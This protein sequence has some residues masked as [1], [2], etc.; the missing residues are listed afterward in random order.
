MPSST[1][2]LG[3]YG[4]VAALCAVL[5]SA[6][7]AQI[8]FGQELLA[9]LNASGVGSS[10]RSFLVVGDSLYFVADRD[11]SRAGVYK[12]TAGDGPRLLGLFDREPSLGRAG[13]RVVVHGNDRLFVSDG[14]GLQGFWTHSDIVLG[15]S[16]GME[17]V[18]T[19]GN[20]W[21]PERLYVTDGT[22]EGTKLLLETT[23][24][25][26]A[27]GPGRGLRNGRLHFIAERGSG[28][29]WLW[30]TDGKSAGTIRLAAL[31]EA[32]NSVGVVRE[33][34]LFEVFDG[35]LKS[36]SL[37]GHGVSTLW[38]SGF[39]GGGLVMSKDSTL[40][41]QTWD[42]D[43]AVTD[44]SPAGTRLIDDLPPG[45]EPWLTPAWF[46]ELPSAAFSD[47]R[48]P[49]KDG[50]LFSARAPGTGLEPWFTTGAA[51]STRS[52]GDL[53]PGPDGS[54][55]RFLLEMGERMYFSAYS[56]S[57][58]WELWVSDGTAPGTRLS[59]D[60][61]PGVGSSAP[62]SAAMVGGRFLLVASTPS[63]G[64]ELYSLTPGA[65][66][67]NL[68]GDLYSLGT[69]DSSPN[70]FVSADGL[71]AFVADDGRTGTKLWTSDGTEAGTF[72]VPG[73]PPG[74]TTR[75]V[76]AEGELFW[77]AQGSVWK[78][79]PRTR[80]RAL[81]SPQMARAVRDIR[82]RA[83]LIAASLDTEVVIM[84]A[85]SLETLATLTGAFPAISG[86]GTVYALAGGGTVHSWRR[87]TGYARATPAP[88]LAQDVRWA[89][90]ADSSYYLWTHSFTEGAYVWH[91]DGKGTR[92]LTPQRV[93]SQRITVESFD[94]RL[95]VGTIAGAMIASGNGLS[96][97]ARVPF[98][99]GFLVDGERAFFTT[100]NVQAGGLILW[101]TDGTPEG[102]I[103][104]I[105]LPDLDRV[106]LIGL[107]GED[108]L[109]VARGE[110]GQFYLASP[111]GVRPIGEPGPIVLPGGFVPLNGPRPQIDAAIVDRS[112]V[113]AARESRRGL[114]PWILHL[115][116]P[117]N[118]QAAVDPFSGLAPEVFPNPATHHV[119]LKASPGA[120][121][122][123][124]D[125]LG[126]QVGQWDV[127]GGEIGLDVSGWPSGVYFLRTASE[128]GVAVAN[129]VVVRR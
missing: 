29:R 35:S 78:H 6:H 40:F 99:D 52:L 41:F 123:A 50:M 56:P 11:G 73:A 108:M 115:P 8:C 44:G 85:Q 37:S 112:V 74:T 98:E 113:F 101:E 95:L 64:N 114:E 82:V 63:T 117:T 102:T 75:P 26:V 62:T 109:L 94:D 84:D 58:G 105:D 1:I 51:G 88:G 91:S 54:D 93:S 22:P 32:D 60:L 16:L 7:G 68:E 124:Y 13:D 106:Y 89:V 57:V 110:E 122:E 97:L 15:P 104:W 38:E 10:P 36:V 61:V 72:P 55:P 4:R 47:R 120:T 77:V 69:A 49:Y 17:L 2:R 70:G 31:P 39:T 33:N 125:V 30:S 25:S 81:R 59:A 3:L 129:L 71:V 86:D 126:Q 87:N 9:D 18:F 19:E 23:W 20:S 21:Y 53:N 66:Q 127:S 111:D 45:V 90:A 5:L 14:Q 76:F 128:R 24:M 107:Y 83:G 118:S 43:L 28:E 67:L 92:R 96:I 34:F 103:E 79:D 48:V 116:S 100:R 12:W 42:G 119:T 65:D 80:D 121:V 46:S 27:Y